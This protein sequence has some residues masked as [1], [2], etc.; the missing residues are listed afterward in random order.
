MPKMHA[1]KSFDG[2]DERWPPPDIQS[3]LILNTVRGA[4]FAILDGK[5]FVEVSKYRKSIDWDH[6]P[7]NPWKKK[8]LVVTFPKAQLNQTPREKYKSSIHHALTR[9]GI[10][11]TTKK[12]IG[13][14]VATL[15]SQYKRMTPERFVH[16]MKILD[17]RETSK[18]ERDVRFLLWNMKLFRWFGSFAL[19]Q[20]TS[21]LLSDGNFSG[22]KENSASL[23]V[24]AMIID[25]AKSMKKEGKN[26]SRF[27]QEFKKIIH[28][29]TDSF[30]ED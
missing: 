15:E 12:R 25:R 20:T 11:H 3:K 14:A 5:D 13:I 21:L 1:P 27:F 10:D 8:T 7:K 22:L 18:L 24:L 2:P 26:G 17:D 28:R 9:V 16:R 30:R 29:A 4:V 19:S 23:A 6:P